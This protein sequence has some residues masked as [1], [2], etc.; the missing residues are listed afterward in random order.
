MV[1]PTGSADSPAAHWHA[2]EMQLLQALVG[3]LG[4]HGEPDPLLH[5]MLQLMAELVGL[6]RGRI[7]LQAGAGRHTIHHAYGLAHE[8]SAHGESAIGHVLTTGQAL[9]VRDRDVAHDGSLF[10]AL[11]I[12]RGLRTIGVLACQRNRRPGRTLEDDLALLR[13]L[14]ALAAHRLQRLDDAA[15]DGAP[16]V[17]P[18]VRTYLPA[19][20]HTVEQ[21][22]HALAEHDGV[23][24]RAAE[25][26]GLTP[27]QFS[28]R[29]RKAR[30]D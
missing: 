24:R 18:L 21:L 1:P 19:A 25:S 17:A 15:D 3:R 28:Y 9:V 12:Q 23:L 20:S 30:G 8:E 10:L 5:A 11:P 16:P 22:E 13:I 7:V 6:N 2:Q 26:L 14:A 4:A 27:R 29:L